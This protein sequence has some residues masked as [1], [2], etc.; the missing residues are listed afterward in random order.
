MTS[1]STTAVGNDI[2]YNG[3][4]DDSPFDLLVDIKAIGDI[5]FAQNEKTDS[6]LFY[7]FPNGKVRGAQVIQPGNISPTTTQPSNY[8]PTTSQNTNA[9]SPT[10]SGNPAT[11]APTA[12]NTI[13]TN[14]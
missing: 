8:N 11:T 12:A 10:Q 5:L 4:L 7:T 9:S 13:D 3:T 6:M 1:L 14:I 2:Y